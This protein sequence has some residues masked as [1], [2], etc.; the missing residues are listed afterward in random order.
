MEASTLRKV[1]RSGK[2]SFRRSMKTD[3]N[4]AK[5]GLGFSRTLSLSLADHHSLTEQERGD[6]EDTRGTAAK[7]P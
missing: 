7:V 3:T 1:L 6:G 5:G 4:R 2:G